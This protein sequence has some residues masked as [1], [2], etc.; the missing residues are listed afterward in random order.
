MIANVS[1]L[2]STIGFPLDLFVRSMRTEFQLLSLP[3]HTC[4]DESRGK[5][6]EGVVATF[7]RTLVP[8]AITHQQ[9]NGN[10]CM[11]RLLSSN[12]LQSLRIRATFPLRV[13]KSRIKPSHSYISILRLLRSKQRAECNSRRAQSCQAH[14]V[15][16][17]SKNHRLCDYR[18]SFEASR[19]I[20]RIDFSS[21][22]HLTIV[23]GPVRLRHACF[24]VDASP[25]VLPLVHALLL[26]TSSFVVLLFISSHATQ[27]VLDLDPIAIDVPNI[28]TVSGSQ[29]LCLEWMDYFSFLNARRPI[30]SRRRSS[31]SDNQCV[32]ST[33]NDEAKH[34]SNCQK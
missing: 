1:R 14:R 25:I 7:E 13:G 3:W 12:A 17:T 30:N 31:N 23:R 34:K 29:R 8:I 4:R 18:S 6:T 24:A 19:I 27:H 28:R 2:F 9:A 15:E 21:V 10:D 16:K 20:P 5:K 26:S 32:L 22:C 33:R 11:K